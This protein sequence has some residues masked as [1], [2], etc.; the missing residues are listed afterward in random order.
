MRK[1]LTNKSIRRIF[2][3]VCMTSALSC[4]TVLP[5]LSFRYAYTL[6]SELT[7]DEGFKS[8][9]RPNHSRLKCCTSPRASITRL[10]SEHEVGS[11]A[12]LSESVVLRNLQTFSTHYLVANTANPRSLP[13]KRGNSSECYCSSC[14]GGPCFPD[15]L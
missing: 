8:F 9:N 2:P 4:L 5:H 1:I 11:S 7:G 12:F 14:C 15:S 10:K 13:V 3:P 6:M